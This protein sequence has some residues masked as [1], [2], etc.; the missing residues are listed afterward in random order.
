M[1]LRNV[2]LLA[3]A[4][5][6]AM[7]LAPAMVFIG[8]IVGG[9]LAIDSRMATLPVA[10][11]VVGTALS[12]IP[13]AM[14]M[15]KL[16]RKRGFLLG[17]AG[18]I[19][20]C[21]L[22]SLA[23]SVQ[24]FWLFVLASACTGF[25]LAFVQQYR[26]AAA[27][28][29]SPE[30]AGKAISFVLVGGVIAAFTGPELARVC[31][32]WLDVRFAGSFL[33]M[34]LLIAGALILLLALQ[35]EADTAQKAVP[36][37]HQSV[38]AFTLFSRTGF[39]IAVTGGVVSYAVMSFIMTATPISMHVMD[40][41]SLDMT[42]RVIQSHVAA[43]Y[44]PSL[45]TGMIIGALGVRNI[46]SLGT[47]LLLACSGIALM[48]HELMHYWW[49]LV[50]LGIG[51]NFLFVGSTTLLTRQYASEERFKAQAVNDFAVFGLQAIA[52]LSAG[53][54]IHQ[55]GWQWVNLLPIPVLLVMLLLLFRMKSEKA[56]TAQQGKV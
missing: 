43:M 1:T 27:E 48:G 13:A 26:F 56:D 23:I 12:T 16:G 52:S 49:A 47:L 37:V 32:D 51:W 7:S 44:L 53:P 30:Q 55:L 40:G 39:L 22:A 25:H 4:S 2:I 34:A 28:S 10:F 20:A 46:M 11:M 19:L 6:M 31:A 35:E 24:S 17:A 38:S 15:Q 18:G 8:G 45:L 36:D 41:H 14:L 9:E 33:A 5:A 29:V 3:F 42:A 50:L 21:L 54:V